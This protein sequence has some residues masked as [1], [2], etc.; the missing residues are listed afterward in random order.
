MVTVPVGVPPAEVTVNPTVTGWPATVGSGVA[1][2]IVVVVPVRLTV[3]GTPGDVLPV[4]FPSPPYVATSVL[5]PGVADVSAQLPAATV[6]AQKAAPS[7]TVTVPV[8]VPAPGALT[9]TA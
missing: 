8:G 3:W 2:E 4:K 6:F 5:G 1:E 7:E 9:A